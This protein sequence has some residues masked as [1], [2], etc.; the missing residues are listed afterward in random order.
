MIDF[1]CPCGCDTRL[2]LRDDLAGQRVRCPATDAAVLVP[3][4][5][6][7]PAQRLHPL[8]S[9]QPPDPPTDEASWLACT[10]PDALLTY[11]LARAD[12][13]KLRLY[14]CACARRVWDLLRFD[15][16]RHAIENAERHADGLVGEA[17]LLAAERGAW[18]VWMG[19]GALPEQA[20]RAAA[21]ADPRE[22]ARTASRTVRDALV[23]GS[24]R[25]WHEASRSVLHMTTTEGRAAAASAV[26][27]ER[28]PAWRATH[29]WTERE[30]ATLL[31]DVFGNPFRPVRA[32]PAWREWNGGCV[33]GMARDIYDGRHFGDLPILADALEEAGCADEQLL[34]HFRSGKEVVHVPG[35][36]GL[37]A[38]LGRM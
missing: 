26:V 19:R 15:A 38:L 14:A 34:G 33:A 32:A 13:R 3:L 31:R 36:W 24:M 16:S 2:S 21:L 28:E 9:W 25:A 20:A 22:A 35:C 7:M 1:I 11:V 5:S 6:G 30:G 8:G 29:V 12:A 17:E 37:D 18:D 4:A 10:N 23:A 27:R